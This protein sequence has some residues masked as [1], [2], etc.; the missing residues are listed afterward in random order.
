MTSKRFGK[1]EIGLMALAVLVAAFFLFAFT[2]YKMERTVGA[3]GLSPRDEQ[4]VKDAVARH[5]RDPESA[6]FGTMATLKPGITCG[7]VNATNAYGAYAG[8][9]LF[10]ANFI[11]GTS[12]ASGVIIA[13]TASIAEILV[14]KCGL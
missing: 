2:S 14:E 6:K 8:E 4:V 5:L 11:P 12:H 13:E 7:T 9:A 3:N 10:M 1:L